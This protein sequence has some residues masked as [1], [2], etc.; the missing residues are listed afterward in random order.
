MQTFKFLLR[1]S[2]E[3]WVLNALTVGIGV[4]DLQTHVD[5]DHAA[6]FHMLTLPFDLDTELHIIAIGTAQEANSLDLLGG[7][8]EDVLSGIADQAQSPNATWCDSE[9]SSSEPPWT[10]RQS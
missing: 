2:G 6:G 5:A 8:G 3:T 4:E 10:E 1:L 7:E 9:P